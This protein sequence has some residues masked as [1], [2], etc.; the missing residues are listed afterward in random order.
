MKTYLSVDVVVSVPAT[1]KSKITAI[2]FIS[3]ISI[4][5]RKIVEKIVE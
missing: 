1:K 5:N 3:A 4:G 2:M